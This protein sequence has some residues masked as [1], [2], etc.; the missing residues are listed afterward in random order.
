ML[1]EQESINNLNEVIDQREK[2]IDTIISS[3][4]T[5]EP[6]KQYNSLYR[7]YSG[8]SFKDLK[9]LYSQLC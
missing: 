1:V 5:V 2:M 3:K 6:D 4:H 7:R 9:K 8:K